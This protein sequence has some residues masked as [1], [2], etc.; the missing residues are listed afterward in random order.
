M[1]EALTSCWF[2]SAGAVRVHTSVCPVNVA[3]EEAAV[4]HLGC[5]LRER[6]QDIMSRLLQ[7]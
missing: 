3:E 1:F 5:Y 7:A 6:Q 2:F 4:H